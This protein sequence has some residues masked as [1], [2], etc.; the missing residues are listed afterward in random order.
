MPD[1]DKIFE[2]A[3]NKERIS[4]QEAFLLFKEGNLIKLGQVASAVRKNFHPDNIVTFVIDRNINYTNICT[5]KCKFCAFYR[6]KEASDAYLLSEGEIFTKIDEAIDL[7][8]TQIMLQGGLH[9]EL[10]IDYFTRLLSAIKKRYNIHIHSF[11]PPEIVH[12]AR[13]SEISTKE[14]LKKLKEAG[15]DSLPGGGAEILVDH[16]RQKISPNKI[17]ADLWLKVMEEAHGVGLKTTATMM[18]GSLETPEDRI[19]HLSC[20]RNLQDKAGGFRAFIPWT[21]QPGHTELGGKSISGAEY[22]RMLAI[23]RIFLDNFKH[24]QGSWVTQGK[25][26][27]QLSLHFGA[28]DLGSIMIE[29]NVVASTGVSYKMSKEEMIELIKGASFFPAQRNTCYEILQTFN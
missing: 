20:L 12:I 26:I 24:L 21:F 14:A 9:P 4:E 22:L 6:E 17:S 1:A 7:G 3:L 25:E 28:N 2:K 27:G 23:S 16:I 11:S 13:N 29:E 15:L 10:K 8:A 18:M 5:S 19:E